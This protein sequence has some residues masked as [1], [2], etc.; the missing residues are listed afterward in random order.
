[1]ATNGK[2]QRA[3]A[4]G[5]NT[6]SFPIGTN[7]GN[8]S[9]SIAFT[10]ITGTGNLEVQSYNTP[11]SQTSLNGLS[12]TAYLKRRWQINNSG[13]NF[14]NANV[15][16]NYLTTDLVGDAKP[17]S[18]RLAQYSAAGWTYPSVSTGLNSITANNVTSFGDFVAATQSAVLPVELV[19]FDGYTEGG[20]NILKWVTAS[21]INTSHF[22]IERSSDGLKNWLEISKPIPA[23]GTTTELK[24]YSETDIF[25]LKQAYYRL[26]MVDF[27]GKIQYS[28]VINI[29]KT[30][31]KKTVLILYPNPIDEKLNIQLESFTNQKTTFEILDIYGRNIQ[32]HY[33]NAENGINN[34]NLNLHQLSK[35][36]YFL[37]TNL[38]GMQVVEKIVKR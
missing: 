28:K 13:L 33:F 24:K 23:A 34:W 8:T 38:E 7:D 37:K 10:G 21:Q 9:V 22:I 19:Y 11:H 14:T 26:K 25:P 12:Q 5:N 32:I 29:Q 18:L 3:I 30:G 6:Y 20:T 4:N 16:F 27:D 35:G 17:S 36:V 2:L 31:D 1:M 15:T